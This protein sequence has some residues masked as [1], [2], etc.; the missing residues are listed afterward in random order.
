MFN[1]EVVN[2]SNLR[3]N[4]KKILDSV[5]EDETQYVINRGKES[6]VLISLDEYNGWKETLHLMGSKKNADRLLRAVDRDNKGK[7]VTKNLLID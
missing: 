5:V 4:L 6:A 1:M 7:Y 3:D 2:Y